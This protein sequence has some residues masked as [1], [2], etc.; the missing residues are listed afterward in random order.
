[1]IGYGMAKAAVHQLVKSLAC[2]K[3]GMPDNSFVAAILPVTL[4]TPM[5]RKFMP[6]ADQTTWTPLETVA[7]LFHCWTQGSNRPVNGALLQLITKEGKTEFV[8]A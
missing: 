1:M 4:D 5:N 8:A 6:N 7:K 3:S 2:S